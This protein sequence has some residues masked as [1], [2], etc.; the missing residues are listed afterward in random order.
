MSLIESLFY[1]LIS[2]L[3][4]FL[5][6]S[7]LG[8]QALML[9]LF[10]LD[11]REPA[12]DVF[13]HIGILV[14]LVSACRAM[15]NHAMAKQRVTSTT[16]RGRRVEYRDSYDLRLVKAAVFP[17]ILGFIT[18]FFVR[19]V[20]KNMAL[21]AVLFIVNGVFIIVR[22][23]F[24]ATPILGWSSMMAAMLFIGGMI[25]L[26]MGMLGEYIGRIYIC[27]NNSPQYVIREIIKKED[28]N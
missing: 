26:M 10:G 27:I 24:D 5:P 25:M 23:L 21:L 12:R 9:R 7:S 6:I 14:A 22:R 17:M 4:E 13:V 1:G 2:G 8:H 19:S 16:R 3:S 28:D 11:N 20:E 18:H 15:F